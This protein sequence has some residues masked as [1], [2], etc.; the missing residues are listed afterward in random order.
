MRVPIYVIRE[1]VTIGPTSVRVMGEPYA[2]RSLDEERFFDPL[3]SSCDPLCDFVMIP[4]DE[5]MPAVQS[6]KDRV[7]FWD[8]DPPPEHIAYMVCHVMRADDG[9][10]IRDQAFSHL[11]DR[12]EWP[13]AELDYIRV[14]VMLVGSKPNVT[15]VLPHNGYKNPF[16]LLRQRRTN[17]DRTCGRT[18]YIST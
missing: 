13:I 8:T 15:H 11:F 16:G 6:V 9:I 1:L 2:G 12:H 3:E 10:V 18:A 7:G 4:E 17:D 5:V 14:S